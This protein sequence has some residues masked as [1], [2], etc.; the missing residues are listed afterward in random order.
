M[1]GVAETADRAVEAAGDSL[2]EIDRARNEGIDLLR[3]GAA[4]LEEHAEK[5]VARFAAELDAER[6]AAA[7]VRA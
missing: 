2:K 6:H 4:A 3:Q 5:E 7:A 1:D